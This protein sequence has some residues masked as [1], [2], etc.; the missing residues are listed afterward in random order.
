M[1][2]G[3]GNENIILVKSISTLSYSKHVHGNFQ[4]KVSS[5]KF[6][7]LGC[8]LNLQKE[9]VLSVMKINIY[10]NPHLHKTGLPNL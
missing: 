9:E 1:V 2:T 8:L 6:Y 10:L 3:N 4:L 7:R 5:H